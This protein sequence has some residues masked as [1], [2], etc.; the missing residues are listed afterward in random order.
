MGGILPF[1]PPHLAWSDSPTASFRYTPLPRLEMVVE[2]I[3]LD[4]TIG[5]AFLGVIVSAVSVPLYCT[6]YILLNALQQALRCDMPP[7]I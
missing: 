7:D 2:H 1:F 5:A 6:E 4:N 3:N